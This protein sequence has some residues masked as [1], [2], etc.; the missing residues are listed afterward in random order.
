[1]KIKKLTTWIVWKI[2][3]GALGIAFILMIISSVF[4]KIKQG[5]TII[6]NLIGESNRAWGEQKKKATEADE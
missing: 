3:L 1:M 5:Y 4:S 6:D 2:F